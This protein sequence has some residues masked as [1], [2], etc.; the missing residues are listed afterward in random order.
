M[1]WP[2]SSLFVPLASLSFLSLTNPSLSSQLHSHPTTGRTLFTGHMLPSSGQQHEGGIQ[3]IRLPSKNKIVQIA[4]HQDDTAGKEIVLWEDVLVV[5]PD[6]LY[7]QDSTKVLPFL[8]GPNFKTYVNNDKRCLDTHS[9]NCSW[10]L[11]I[12]CIFFFIDTTSLDPPR[13]AA[14]PGIVLEVV[15][16][17]PVVVAERETV[18]PPYTLQE[19]PQETPLPVTPERENNVASSGVRRNPV[20]GEVEAAMENYTHIDRPNPNL[21]GPQLAPN[22]YINQSG[23]RNKPLPP[24]NEQPRRAPQLY[25]EGS[26]QSV[27]GNMDTNISRDLIESEREAAQQGDARSQFNLGL[28]YAHGQGGVSQDHA[29]AMKW[30]RRAAEQGFADAFVAI[31]VMYQNGNGVSKDYTAAM[32][33]YHKGAKLGN[34]DAEVNIG[35]LYRS[36]LGVRQDYAMAIS[37]YFKA[38]KRV[39]A[40]AQLNVGYMYR[41]GFGV[42]QDFSKAMEWYL[43]AAEQGHAIAQANIGSMYEFARGVTKNYSLALEWYLKAARQGHPQAQKNAGGLYHLGQG[44]EQDYAKAMEWYLRAAEQGLAE[45]Q[46]E[47]GSLYMHGQGVPK[48]Y[49]KAARWYREA[50]EQGVAKAQN[51]LGWMYEKGLGVPEDY[52]K[53]LEWYDKA[54]DQ[55]LAEAQENAKIMKSRVISDGRHQQQQQRKQATDKRSTF[56]RVLAKVLA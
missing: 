44:I 39:N 6:A 51:H 29:A 2:E 31:G 24:I 30:F 11:T 27:R 12:A 52:E 3:G 18:L 46:V 37:W 9:V 14:V 50:A 41:N 43:K 10:T 32:E 20:Y 38:A 33:L 4:T 8:K 55:G 56:S 1:E 7:L 49:A 34:A 21:P 54:A 35:F 5:F 19:V 25:P 36:G 45:A 47:L 48:D 40:D 26:S 53:A 17:E 23:Y 22:N 28:R 42:P 13:I 16:R 15:V